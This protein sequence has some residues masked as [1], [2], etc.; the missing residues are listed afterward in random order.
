MVQHKV[1]FSFKY[2]LIYSG[3]K[4]NLRDLLKNNWKWKGAEMD[5]N[6]I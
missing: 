6:W 3:V 5:Q 1:I 2:T 4:Y